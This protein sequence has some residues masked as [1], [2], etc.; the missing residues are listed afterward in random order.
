VKSVLCGA[1]INM[2]CCGTK[3]E[4]IVPA[5]EYSSESSHFMEDVHNDTLHEVRRIKDI[6]M[7]F[8]QEVDYFLFPVYGPETGL[9]S[10]ILS[11]SNSSLE[12]IL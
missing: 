11:P 10:P 8:Y 12:L 1:T 3:P 4:I 2:G 7:Q 6:L 5:E 9:P